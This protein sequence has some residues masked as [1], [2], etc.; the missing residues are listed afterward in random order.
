MHFVIYLILTILFFSCE[1]SSQEERRK[2][3]QFHDFETYQWHNH[4]YQ[5]NPFSNTYN[6]DWRDHPNFYDHD[7]ESPYQ[8]QEP[9]QISRLEKRMTDFVSAQE[10]F[11]IE[12]RQTFSKVT[13]P[14]RNRPNF[15][16]Q[17]Y[18]NP[19]Q[20]WHD[21]SSSI[22]RIEQMVEQ[23][24]E[25]LNISARECEASNEEMLKSFRDANTKLD[26]VINQWD[27]CS[28]LLAQNAQ[29]FASFSAKPEELMIKP[30][31]NSREHN[32]AMAIEG[33]IES[34]EPHMVREE[35]NWQVEQI[36]KES[37]KMESE[38]PR[39]QESEKMP[40]EEGKSLTK[41]SESPRIERYIPPQKRERYISTIKSISSS[42]YF[43]ESNS[44]DQI[45][46]FAN[47]ERQRK[48]EEIV[49][50]P[51]L[52]GLFG[53]NL[54]NISEKNSENISNDSPPKLENSNEISIP[55]SI[56]TTKIE[57]TTYDLEANV[58]PLPKEI[59]DQIESGNF[60]STNKK[61]VLADGSIQSPLGV[62]KNVVFKNEKIKIPAD[63][64]VLENEKGFQSN[65]LLGQ[66]I[67]TTAG[68]HNKVKEGGLSFSM[69]RTKETFCYTQPN[70]PSTN[71]NL[72]HMVEILQVDDIS[73]QEKSVATSETG[74]TRESNKMSSTWYSKEKY[75]N[76]IKNYKKRRKKKFEAKDNLKRSKK[77]RNPLRSKPRLNLKKGSS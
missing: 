14:L 64:V 16:D 46:N 53:E 34:K 13:N 51:N 43:V 24:T 65:N 49:Q 71:K 57:M 68:A 48:I 4:Q 38:S 22:S 73:S 58:S 32:N 45:G 59:F 74:K 25:R 23:M 28:N 50:M 1:V 18:E 6:F 61:F 55:P 75:I 56:S 67:L 69:G 44:N 12:Q 15:Y 9:S 52:S 72:V 40:K 5:S 54:T 30:K 31:I 11:L 3:A 35:Q 8:N 47:Q 60:E 37:P 29:Q 19:F 62:L 26:S 10:N 7:Y 39:R 42:Q 33:E 36:E 17:E 27:R 41:E 63:F 66:I 20:N 21:Q 70:I 2:M 77:R 76:K